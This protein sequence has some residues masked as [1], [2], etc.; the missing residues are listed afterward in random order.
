MAARRSLNLWVLSGV[1]GL[2]FIALFVI[3]VLTPFGQLIDAGSL[4]LFGWLRSDAWLAFY[5]GRDIVMYCVLAGAAVAALSEVL[6]HRWG[7]PAYSVLLLAIVGAVSIGMKEFVVRP[8]LGDFAYSHNTFPSGHTAM[9]LAGAVAIIWCGSRWMSPV[10]V[11][12]LGGLVAFVALSSV[13]S[14]AHRASDSI[15]GVLLAGAVSCGLAA[16]SR[17]TEPVTTRRRKGTV[18]AGA[19]TVGV[20]LIY[21]A[22]ALGLSGGGEH[23]LQ[24]AIAILL[25]TL[26]LIV[27]ILAVHRPFLVEASKTQLRSEATGEHERL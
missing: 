20:G 15:G 16:L 22:G 14:M 18:I 19:V 13:F 2:G 4:S 5:D 23:G 17:E 9:V 26:G 10:L 1:F 24:L 21:L 11:L 25:C 12:V 7:P 27:S 3:A 8:D 6:Q